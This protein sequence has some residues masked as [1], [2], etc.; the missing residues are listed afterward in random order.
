LGRRVRIREVGGCTV[1]GSIMAYSTFSS[2]KPSSA[3]GHWICLG[4]FTP[5]KNIKEEGI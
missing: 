1:V 3:C 4:S 5:K 2:S